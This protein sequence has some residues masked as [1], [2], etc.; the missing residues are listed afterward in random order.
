MMETDESEPRMYGFFVLYFLHEQGDLSG[1]KLAKIIKER[2]KGYFSSTPGNIYPV[3]QSLEKKGLV[4]S[5]KPIGKRKKILYKITPKGMTALRDLAKIYKE[6][7]EKITSFF[8]K[9]VKNSLP[10]FS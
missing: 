8:D 10:R 1:Y 7:F 3:L 9:V 2:T 6:R 5:S 4:Q